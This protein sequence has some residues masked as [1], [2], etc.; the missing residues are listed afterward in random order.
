MA[1]KQYEMC[2]I[3]KLILLHVANIN[4]HNGMFISKLMQVFKKNLFSIGVVWIIKKTIKPFNN[5][6]PKHSNGSSFIKIGQFIL[7]T[8]HTCGKV[9]PL[10]AVNKAYASFVNNIFFAKGLTYLLLRRLQY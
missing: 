1:K 6:C 7:V 10:Y 5:N 3:T 2:M 8:V 9:S 4:W